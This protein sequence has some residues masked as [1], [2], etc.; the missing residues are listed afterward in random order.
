MPQTPINTF[1]TLL[2]IETMVTNGTYFVEKQ[3]D[4]LNFCSR[5]MLEIAGQSIPQKEMKKLALNPKVC[6]DLKK[7][8]KNT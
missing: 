4:N 5:N 6:K 2:Y 1:D 3:G 8:K 7:K